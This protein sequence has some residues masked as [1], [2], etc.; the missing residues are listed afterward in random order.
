M[1]GLT[2]FIVIVVIVG[3]VVY[4]VAKQPAPPPGPGGSTG[5]IFDPPQQQQ[6]KL[7]GEQGPYQGRVIPVSIVRNRPAFSIG[8]ARNNDLV[9]DGDMV[10]SGQHA[11][12]ALAGPDR[13]VLYDRSRNGTY[14]NEHRVAHHNLR[15]GDRIRIGSSVFLFTADGQSLTTPHPSLTGTLQLPFD[16]NVDLGYY[17]P[18][19]DLGEGGMARVIKAQD[20]RNQATVAIKFLIKD[21]PYIKEKFKYEIRFGKTSQH[22]HIARIYGGGIGQNG[23]L[24]YVAEFIDGWTLYQ[25]L[26]HQPGP[27]S[28]DQTV[29]I[30][31]QVCD[32]LYYAH[33]CGV[34]HRDIKPDNIM[35][36][37]QGQVKLIDFGIARIKTMSHETPHGMI[38]GTP[39]YISPEQVKGE[40]DL[41]G[42]VD[43]YSLGVVL[44]QMLTGTLPFVSNNPDPNKRALELCHHHVH[45]PPPLLRRANQSIP[46]PMEQVVLRCL[47][48]DKNR[49]YQNAAELAQ[50]VGYPT[51][52]F[53]RPEQ[54]GTASVRAQLLIHQTRSAI[55]LNATTTPLHRQN[56]NPRDQAI[57]RQCH[58]EITNRNGLYWLS[59]RSKYGAFLNEMRLDQAELLQPGDQIRI[60]QTL[61]EF[62]IA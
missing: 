16:P 35:L 31:G 59:A 5:P 36:T 3:V 57:S 41:D 15:S 52:S 19:Q 49:R 48:K 21:N 44:Y 45:T 12:L 28:P 58:A 54:V 46:S 6:T 26:S 22:P 4:F 61:L 8:R 37:P 33:N 7:V 56:V 55:L 29:P 13:W 20:T 42:R 11:E 14:V 23:Q 40:R 47:E 60:G 50:A 25:W 27:L 24:Y 1:D 10:V 39:D 30:V 38:V 2:L 43:V 53:T 17:K 51:R 62:Q 34:Y 18:I 32:A 9:L